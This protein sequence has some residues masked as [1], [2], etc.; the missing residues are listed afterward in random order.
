MVHLHTCADGAQVVEHLGFGPDR[1]SRRSARV[2]PSVGS[3]W[4]SVPYRSYGSGVTGLVF[5]G[6][7]ESRSRWGAA[8]GIRIRV[9]ILMCG[10]SPRRTAS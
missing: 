10:I 2:N 5:S 6:I 8:F 3:T 1:E 4:K 9:P 7:A